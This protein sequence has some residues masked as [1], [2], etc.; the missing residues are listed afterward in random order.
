LVRAAI[1]KVP[2]SQLDIFGIKLDDS[3]AADPA[4]AQ[5]RK[6]DGLNGRLLYKGWILVW[7]DGANK[8]LPTYD[9][10]MMKLSPGK[11]FSPD[12]KHALFVHQDFPV[13]PTIDDVLFLISQTH[14]PRIP[15]RRVYRKDDE[16]RKH[17]Y[18]LAPEPERK[19]AVLAAP[20]RQHSHRDPKQNKVKEKHKL[21][22]YEAV[23]FMMVELGEDFHAKEKPELKRQ[24]EFYERVPTFTNRVDLRSPEEPWYRFEMRHWI[25]SR[26]IVH[27]LK[28][29]ESRQLRCEWY[30]E[31]VQWGNELDQ[32]SFAYIMAKRELKRR[33]AHEEPDDH[34]KPVYVQHPELLS[35]TDA[36]EWHAL[37]SEENRLALIHPTDVIAAIPQHMIEMDDHYGK[38][39]D[40]AEEQMRLHHSESKHH[41]KSVPLY[42]RIMSERVMMLARRAWAEKHAHR[43]KKKRKK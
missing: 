32:L 2:P 11:F 31:H 27:D 42:V 3:E 33:I 20:L 17:K 35:L 18:R 9:K 25:R 5:E 12:V 38:E 22:V 10:F 43:Q 14:R 34:I 29:E 16:G 36:H 26:W 7:V 37:E 13:S 40:A 30:Q 1:E 6:L 21:T 28:L 19:A 24:R 41:D 23:K 4:V 39:E 15:E 8:E